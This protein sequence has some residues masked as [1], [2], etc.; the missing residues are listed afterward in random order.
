MSDGVTTALMLFVRG[1]AWW[2][3]KRATGCFSLFSGGVVMAGVADGGG[4][5]LGE[6]LRRYCIASNVAIMLIGNDGEA[7]VIMRNTALVCYAMLCL[8]PR[9]L[10][11]FRFS[12]YLP[13]GSPQQVALLGLNH[14]LDSKL[15]AL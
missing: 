13:D 8:S 3:V 10:R 1:R 15:A 5:D 11:D 4:S 14:R 9:R 12:L 7:G 2:P 6:G